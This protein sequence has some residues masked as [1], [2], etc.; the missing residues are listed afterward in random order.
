M[1]CLDCGQD[2]APEAGFCANCGTALEA[3]VE[4]LTGKS[5][6]KSFDRAIR[7]LQGNEP[8]RIPPPIAEGM[9]KLRAYRGGAQGVAHAALEG[10]LV[11]EIEAELVLSLVAAYITYLVDLF[12]Q[13]EEEIPF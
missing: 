2:N 4:V 13:E 11:S 12:P 3:S 5:V 7:Q 10:S 9:I 6:S 1:R 8:G